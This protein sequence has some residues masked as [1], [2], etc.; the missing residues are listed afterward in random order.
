M[1]GL[2]PKLTFES[3]VVGPSRRLVCTAARR[4]A[5]K[6]IYGDLD[7]LLLDDVQF[8]TDPG[9]RGAGSRAAW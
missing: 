1:S 2:D 7:V 3:F 4:A 9:Q 6:N 8:L 5:K